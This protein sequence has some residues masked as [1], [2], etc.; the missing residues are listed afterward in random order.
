MSWQDELRKLDS[1]LVAGELTADEYRQRRDRVMI[2]A[3]GQNQPQGQQPAPQPP[4]PQQPTPQQSAP[5]PPQAQ[6]APGTPP[7]GNPVPGTPPGGNPAVP[8]PNANES[9]QIVAPISGGFPVPPQQNPAQQNQT[10]R[11]QVVPTQQGQNPQIPQNQPHQQGQ[12]DAGERTQVVPS[13]SLGTG[14]ADSD[15]TQIVPG[16]AMGTGQQ[17]Q[18]GMGGPPQFPPPQPR[19]AWE[20]SR[21]QQQ[22]PQQSPPPWMSDDGLPPDFGQAQSWPRQGP[23]VFTES[24]G[25][26]KGKVIGIVAAVVVLVAAGVAAFLIF[27]PGGGETAAP[28]PGSAPPS[29]TV[30]TSPPPKLP[31]GPF[32]K[33]DDGE[34]H[35]N[36]NISIERAVTGKVPAPDEA[37]FLKAQGV[38]SVGMYVTMEGGTGGNALVRAVYSFTP[39]AGSDPKALLTAVDGYFGE[40][41]HT[42]LSGLPTGVV[43][44][45]M[46]A[47]NDTGRTAFRAFY[48]ADGVVLQI[49]AFGP[50]EAAAKNAFDALVSAQ[51][52]KFAPQA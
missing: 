51:T 16:R 41:G 48:V 46:A 26:G 20:T 15:R 18:P 52:E 12:G 9:T 43:G 2:E 1:A 45:T 34:E 11:T 22:A 35:A 25:G 31:K 14:P 8:P 4:A 38:T 27:K 37:N 24:S 40:R 39:A 6:Q 3:S 17:P 47:Q 10:E 42:S 49:E 28:G 44:R 32:V 36:Q 23:E 21:P 7:G 19:P 33:I 29:T 30:S 13:G 50:D 5:Q